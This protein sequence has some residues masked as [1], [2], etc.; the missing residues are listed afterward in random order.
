M[1]TFQDFQRRALEGGQALVEFVAFAIAEHKNSE[2]YLTAKMADEYDR[3]KNTTIYNYVRT[4]F[5][6][7]GE[8]IEDFTATN[9]RIA[10]N[11]FHRLNT[12]RCVYSLGNGITFPDNEDGDGSGAKLKDDLGQNFDT[13]MKDLAYYA[14]I[15]G[16][17][18]GFW[19]LDKLYVF[20]VTEFV[21]MWD[22]LDGSLRAGIRFWQIDENKPV[23]AVLYEEDGFTK[24]STASEIQQGTGTERRIVIGNGI[25]FKEVQPKRGY[26]GNIKSTKATGD[27][28]VGYEN[29]SAL[30]IIPMW[31][32]KLHQSTLI[33]MR[34]AID[35]FDLIRSGF[36]NDLSDCTQ[37]YW[38]VEN[39]AGMTDEDLQRFR[40]K[41]KIQRIVEVGTGEDGAKVTP[42]TQDIPFAARQA[43]LNDIRAGIYEDFGGLDVHQVNADSTNDHLEAAYQPMDENADDFEFQ[44]I[45]F[46]QQLLKVAGLG[47]NTPVFKRNRI[48]NVKEQVE[49]VLSEAQYLDEETLLNKLPNIS[50]DEVETIRQNRQAEDM[51][52]MTMYEQL[53][54]GE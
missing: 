13:R 18:F 4:I 8:A 6:A 39:C 29:Y 51:Q 36:A 32:S 15:H 33:G 26:V 3:Q 44:I 28:V 49:I 25:S 14:L 54:G 47:E 27:E 30:P 1:I 19:N 2:L 41:L 5:S 24:F 50:P 42:Y 16:V 38:L 46:I 17:S 40:D 9:N 23:I 35:S 10:S 43:Y 21:P 34:H 7:S 37:I 31:G 11:F 52:R 53:Q 20:P 48:S 12:Q 22:E 45:E